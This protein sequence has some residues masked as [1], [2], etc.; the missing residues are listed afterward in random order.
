MVNVLLIKYCKRG[1]GGGT[2]GAAHCWAER[3]AVACVA[4]GVCSGGRGRGRGGIRWASTGH[5]VQA[6]GTARL[7][8]VLRLVEHLGDGA[9][10]AKAREP[11]VCAVRA[12][13]RRH[14]AKTPNKDKKKQAENTRNTRGWEGAEGVRETEWSAFN[15]FGDNLQADALQVTRIVYMPQ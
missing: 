1:W 15:I 2:K 6:R 13:K 8:A 10:E 7:P 5:G 11:Q 14:T 3:E 9:R 12:L 4:G